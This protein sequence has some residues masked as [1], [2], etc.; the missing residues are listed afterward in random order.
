M[1]AL[2]Y[3][4]L[5]SGDHFKFEMSPIVP[6]MAAADA[7]TTLRVDTL[8][9]GNDFRHPAIVARELAAL[10]VLSNGRLEFG[11]GTGW[12]QADYDKPGIALDAPGV[13]VGRLEEAIQIYKRFFSGEP[14]DF[15]GKHYTITNLSG[16]PK[17]IQQPHPPLLIGGGYK[18]M[19]SIAGREADIV[20][21]NLRTTADGQLDFTSASV[22]ATEEKIAWVRQ[23]AG[24]RFA[25]LEFN[26]LLLVVL[27]TDDPHQALTEKFAQWGSDLR[28]II[29]IISVE[30][31]LASPHF[32]VGT[33]DEIVEILQARRKRFGISYYTLFG[34]DSIDLF[35]PIVSRLA[36]T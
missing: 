31:M 19:L 7:T 15:A 3:S 20:G 30:E 24:D 25:H 26:I 28:D 6:L 17:P 21:I 29:K 12:E 5:S 22:A 8:V 27:V 34:E 33:E 32:L 11:L 9:L 4:T 10:D 13:R 23:A 16:M 18:R 1:E 35:A 2:G 36:G 14:F